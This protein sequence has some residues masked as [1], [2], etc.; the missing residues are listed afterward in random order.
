[1]EQ[2]K[3]I[4]KNV[5]KITPEAPS[6]GYIPPTLGSINLIQGFTTSTINL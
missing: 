4:G 5:A 3:S 2:L 1:M 6:A